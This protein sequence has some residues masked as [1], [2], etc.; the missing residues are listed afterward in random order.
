[1]VTLS[2]LHILYI[3][4]LFVMLCLM[5]FRKSIVLPCI[6]GILIVGSFATQSVIGGVQSLFHSLVWTGKEFWSII[7]VISIVVAMSKSLSALGADSLMVRP[8]VRYMKNRSVTFLLLGFAMF[9]VSI[10]LW[11]SPA[12]ALVG[13]V[14]LP[15]ALETGIPVVWAA[16]A[17]NLFGHGMALSG[18]FFIQGAPTITAKAA[19]TTVGAL[20][21]ESFVLWAVMA[22]VTATIAFIMFRRDI[23]NLPPVTVDRSAIQVEKAK[24]AA[25]VIAIAT[26]SMFLLDV[27]LMLIFKLQ[28]SDATALV[29]GTALVILVAATCLNGGIIN[30]FEKVIDHLKEGFGFGIDI[31]TPV[32][33]IAGFFFLGGEDCAKDVLGAQTG[34]MNDI[35]LYLAQNA[36][37]SR[38]PVV[39]AEALAGFVTGL[40]GSGFSG[41]PI[42][43]T[44]AATFAQAL[45]VNKEML[46][47]LGQIVTIWVDG[48]TLIPWAVIPVAAICG[49]RP[50]ELVQKNLIPV[51]SG[52][53]ATIIVAC[54]LV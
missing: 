40:D 54:F 48:G 6:A 27:V 45:P 18:D 46:A 53:A 42:V 21:Q 37:M 5:A 29:G 24:P 23:R 41:L 10:C 13:A 30:A 35:G 26:P 20:I 44:T 16:V 4:L 36:P 2:Y 14:I 51:F 31:F 25:V 43:G 32:I 8:F 22:V 3:T 33:F 12:V 38:I 11:P 1:M 39:L 49:V 47:A 52:L 9:A 15:L 50:E 17:M 7:A 28:G 19:D 34:I